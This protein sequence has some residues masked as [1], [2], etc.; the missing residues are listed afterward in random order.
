MLGSAVTTHFDAQTTGFSAF[1]FQ[2]HRIWGFRSLLLD[3]YPH[4]RPPDHSVEIVSYKFLHLLWAWVMQFV[5]GD[6]WLLFHLPKN[7]EPPS[8]FWD[9]FGVL[10]TDA[11]CEAGSETGGSGGGVTSSARRGVAAPA[12]CMSLASDHLPQLWSWI[13][14][15][16]I[17]ILL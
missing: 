16:N 3:T 5:Y 12:A 11:S 15:I 7:A 9:K 6:L 13:T 2:D 4:T 8:P 1:W 17:T 14:P 10:C